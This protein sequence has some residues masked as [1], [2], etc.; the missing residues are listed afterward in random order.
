M[1]IMLIIMPCRSEK[2]KQVRLLVRPGVFACAPR[3][4]CLCGACGCELG[5]CDSNLGCGGA[6]R[7]R[8]GACTC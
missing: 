8:G 3:R 7:L 6:G 5:N 2:T 4:V 1:S